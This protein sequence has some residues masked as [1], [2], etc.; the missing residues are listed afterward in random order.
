MNKTDPRYEC[1]ICGGRWDLGSRLFGGRTCECDQDTL[2]LF[3]EI[4][5]AADWVTPASDLT[6]IPKGIFLLVSLIIIVM[7]FASHGVLWG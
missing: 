4:G 3:L 1:P 2:D 6:G 5:S 7:I